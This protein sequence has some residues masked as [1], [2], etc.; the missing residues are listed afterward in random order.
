MAFQLPSLGS[1]RDFLVAA[2][3]SLFPDRNVGTRFSY[4]GRRLTVLSAAVTQIH[5]HVDSIKLDVMP[6]TAPDGGPIQRWGT[7]VGCEQKGATPSRKAAAGR[8]RGTLA[9]TAD[10]DEEL[11]HQASGLTFKLASSVTIP[12]G[13]YQDA[14]IV[15]V[16]T[17]SATRLA[18][19]E[20]LEFVNTPANIEQ[21]IVLQKAL[22]EDGFDVEPYG[23][24]RKRVLDTFSA[25][26]AGGTQSDYER[27]ALEIDGITQAYVYPN[28]AGFGT[29]DVAVLH[30]G[31][32]AARIPDPATRADVLEYLK[33]KAPAHSAGVVG[34][35]RVLTPIADPKIV[36]IMIFPDGAEANAFDWTD[37]TPP[38]VIAY[39]AGTKEVQFSGGALPDTLRA[40]HRLSFGGVATVQDGTEFTIEAITG[41]DTVIL[42]EAPAV[43][44]AATDI[45]YS[46]GPLV[47][48]IRN[49]LLGHVNGE[50]VYLAK[51]GT[52]KS[53]ST[54]VSEDRTTVGLE[55]VAYGIG[56]ANPAGFYG[57]WNGALLGDA[58]RQIAMAKN[59]VRK[60]T[61][62]LPAADY[63][64]TD[65]AFPLDSQIGL[66]TPQRVLV[67][68]GW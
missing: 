34:S 57:T 63:E 48:P 58:V 6:D 42:S 19:G 18:A 45:I 14:D 25:P 52:P 26:T 13:L 62:V 46:G 67:R 56:T 23:A 39:T 51:G 11:V 37:Q 40:G 20:V 4:H 38:T 36:E 61:L 60:T 53:E 55:V 54:L 66:I 30:S 64:A 31:T 59:G 17:G 3:K 16:D 5:R 24:Y 28:R 35:L 49:A 21:Q 10:I 12:A 43:D 7:I 32:G 47:T 27:W 41:A 8:V 65:F 44:P 15:A 50:I 22:D 68:R 33:T 29:V 1:T 2:F 9:A